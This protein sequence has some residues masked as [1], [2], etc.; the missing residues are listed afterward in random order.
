[1]SIQQDAFRYAIKNAYEHKGKANQGAVLGKL[2]ALYKDEDVKYLALVA[3][4]ACDKVNSFEFSEIERNFKVFDVQG[5][6]LKPQQGRTGL[7]NLDWAEKGEK[8][9]TRY[10]P[11]PNGPMH[12]G[13]ARAAFLSYAY[14]EKYSGKFI[15]RFEDTDP[16]VKKPMKDPEK[17][18]KEDLEWLGIRVSEI[19]FASDRLNIYY[20]YMRKIIRLGKAYVCF[21]E[22]EEWKEKILTMQPCPCRGKKVEEHLASFEKMV[23]HELTEG[24]CVLRL[25]T[26]LS[27]KDPSVRDWWIARIIDNPDHPRVG[28]KFHVW[29]S[30]MFQ[31]AIDDHELGITL[32]LRGQE[33][34]QNQTKQEYL[35]NYFGWKYPHAIHFGRFSIGNIVLSTSKT[36]EGIEKGFYKGWDDVRLGT[37]KAF[38]R[39]GFKPEALQKIIIDSG[40]TASDAKISFDKLASYNRELIVN[41]A[42]RTPFFKEVQQIIIEKNS[43]DFPREIYVEKQL[44]FSNIGKTLRLK[45][46]FAITITRNQKGFFGSLSKS[47][48]NYSQTILWI[49]KPLEVN[50]LLDDNSILKGFIE[51]TNL[52]NGEYFYLEKIGF[53]IVDD[54]EKSLLCYSHY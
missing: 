15:L 41:Q 17:V 32:I 40:L 53:F 43:F 25:K 11:N 27:H 46:S 35:Y 45:N 6:E 4:E 22:P 29:P 52:N 47:T 18:F 54:K 23:S 31:S 7:P 5:W 16:K 10:A 30:Y 49:C 51:S 3:K 14:A 42:K 8:V 50:L 28:K 33:H 38:R 34:S 48:Q 37:L 19:Y 1:M 9:I 44:A 26:D 39:R 24:S 36:K 13:N 21:C 2:K 20:D 12:L